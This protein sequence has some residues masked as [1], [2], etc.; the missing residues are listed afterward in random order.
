M[1]TSNIEVKKV[2]LGFAAINKTLVS[3][4]PNDTENAQRGKNYVYWGDSDDYANF[5]YDLYENCTTLQTI[6]NGTADYVAGNTIKS[7]VWNKEFINHKKETLNDL[8]TKLSADYLI[9]GI[10]YIQVVRNVAGGIAELY[11]VDAREMRS[12]EDGVVFY[13]SKEFGKKYGRTSKTLVYPAY[14]ANGKDPVS[15]VCIKNPLS[16]GTYGTPVWKGAIKSVLADTKIDTFHLSELDNNFSA[17]AIINFNNG[18]PTEEQVDEIE[19]N[20]ERKFTGSENAGRFL[21]SFN[22]GR[23][24]ET[25]IQRLATDDFDKRYESL[26]DKSQKNIFMSFAASPVLFGVQTESSGWND[27]DYAQA[28]KLYQRTKVYPIQK[29]FV[30][31]F[32]SIFNCKGSIKIEPFSIDWSEESKDYVVE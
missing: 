26:E 23:T 30:D 13:Y 16:R 27:Q 24:N 4:I 11:W 31:A 17:S 22:N 15:I 18:Q 3:S 2:N 8:I 9:F 21:L 6:I 20:I 5:L 25:T 29:R 28:F 32:D 14:Y 19:K 7:N 10:C 1:D 12:D